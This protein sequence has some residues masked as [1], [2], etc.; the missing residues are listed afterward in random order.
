MAIDHEFDAM[1]KLLHVQPD[2]AQALHSNIAM[3]L[4][5]KLGIS[6]EAA[7]LGGATVLRH[8]FDVDVTTHEH[9]PYKG[10]DSRAVPICGDMA[11]ALYGDDNA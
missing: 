4:M 10:H 9:Y 6:H 8:L 11:E 7:N 5:D 1:K 3:P 2:Y